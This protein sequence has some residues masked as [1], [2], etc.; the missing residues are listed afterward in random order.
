[1]KP[2]L[3]FQFQQKWRVG[4]NYT[5]SESVNLLEL[6]GDK[7]KVDEM[8]AEL[9]YSFVKI[10]VISFKFSLY[11]VQFNGNVSSPLAYDMLQGLSTGNNQL[12][13]I[14]FQQRIGQNLQINMSYD[15]R[16]SGLAPIIHTGKMEARYLF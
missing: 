7:S 15:G 11:Q 13:G 5:Y 12:W 4:I 9:R 1:L 16:K 6:G 3:T 2:K 8:G 14:N 10:G